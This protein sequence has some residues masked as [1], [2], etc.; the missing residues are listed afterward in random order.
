MSILVN[1][2]VCK[3]SLLPLKIQMVH[4]VLRSEFDYHLAKK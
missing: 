3:I 1:L 2:V 4:T